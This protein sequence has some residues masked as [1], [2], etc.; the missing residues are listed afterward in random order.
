MSGSADAGGSPPGAAASAAAPPQLPGPAWTPELALSLRQQAAKYEAARR[1]PVL[2]PGDPLDRST[3][4]VPVNWWYL[5]LL[6]R[7]STCDVLWPIVAAMR[8]AARRAPDDHEAAPRAPLLPREFTKNNKK[9]QELMKELTSF[10]WRNMPWEYVG[11]P[12]NMMYT[13]KVVI[14]NLTP[15]LR[16]VNDVETAY[17]YCYSDEAARRAPKWGELKNIIGFRCVNELASSMLTFSWPTSDSPEAPIGAFMPPHGSTI[18]VKANTKVMHLKL[19][20][21]GIPNVSVSR[22]ENI[23]VR[24]IYTVKEMLVAMVQR[25][26]CLSGS[27][28]SP[29]HLQLHHGGTKL[30]KDM[31]L[32]ALRDTMPINSGDKLTVKYYSQTQAPVDEYVDASSMYSD[33]VVTHIYLGVTPE[34]IL[35]WLDEDDAV[36]DFSD[37]GAAVG[38][39]PGAA[40]A[41]AAGGDDDDDDDDDYESP[42]D[43][44]HV[45]T[46]VQQ[47]MEQ[48]QHMQELTTEWAAAAAA[49]AAV[50]PADDT[51]DDDDNTDDYGEL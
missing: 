31:M 36:P 2:S 25:L 28:I 6:D 16:K 18:Y 38:S 34:R 41:A 13:W 8:E 39:P 11:G 49:V 26:P 20:F 35:I 40:A 48:A 22:V 37:A 27:G 44:Q 50:P 51:D 15:R 46:V 7:S 30:H 23:H 32:Y 19:A 45:P 5:R 12:H 9:K 3:M 4:P 1:A 47:V 17:C 24:L 43:E 10:V 29:K 42:E 21:Q 14:L 33:V